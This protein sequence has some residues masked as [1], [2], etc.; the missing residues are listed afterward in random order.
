LAGRRSRLDRRSSRLS[1]SGV[2]GN[3][4]AAERLQGWRGGIPH[5]AKNER[6]TPNF[7]HAALDTTACA[8]FFKERRMKF[9]EPRTFTGN[10]GCGAPGFRLLVEKTAGLST[11]LRSPGFP[12]ELGG[13]GALHAAFLNESSTR[14]N[15]QRC[16]AGNPGPVEMTI[17]FAYS[18][19]HFQE[20][21]AEPQIPR[22]R[23][24]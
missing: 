6:D 22:L 17:L 1:C 5:L 23:S 2:L 16:V 4:A 13:V 7:L 10:R 21:S 18:V 9:T 24:G 11:T 8:P 15:V 3:S 20:G 19:P 14:G 12:V